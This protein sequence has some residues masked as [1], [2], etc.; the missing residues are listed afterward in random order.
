[1]VVIINMLV[2]MYSEREEDNL[3]G[4]I[5]LTPGLGHLSCS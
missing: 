4:P 3:L 1:M 5:S 2:N